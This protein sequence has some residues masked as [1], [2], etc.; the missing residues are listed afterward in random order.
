MKEVPQLSK[1]LQPPH[2]EFLPGSLESFTYIRL[3][4]VN[5]SLNLDLLFALTRGKIFSPPFFSS[6][7]KEGVFKIYL[8]QCRQRDRKPRPGNFGINKLHEM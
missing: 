8:S 4:H 6:Q 1:Y 7:N 5:K 3:T 2:Q